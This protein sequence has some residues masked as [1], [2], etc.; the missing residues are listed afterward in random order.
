[1][2]DYI[3]EKTLEGYKTGKETDPREIINLTNKLQAEI[4]KLRDEE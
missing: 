2:T 1:M 3:I 4:I